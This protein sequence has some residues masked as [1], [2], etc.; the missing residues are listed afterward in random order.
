MLDSQ[1]LYLMENSNNL[2]KIGISKNPSKRR[3]QLELTS[4]MKIKIL[5]CWTCLDATAYNVEQYLHRLFSRRRTVGEW[6]TNISIPDI[7]YAGY[8]LLEC[9]QDGTDKRRD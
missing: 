1:K 7:E 6:F 2:N 3:R 9:N 8:E 5:K 4:G